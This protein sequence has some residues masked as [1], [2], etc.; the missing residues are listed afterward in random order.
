MVIMEKINLSL[1]KIDIYLIKKMSLHMN[2]SS[3]CLMNLHLNQ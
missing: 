3:I 1:L 2:I